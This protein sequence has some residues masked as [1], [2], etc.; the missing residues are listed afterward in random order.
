[1]WRNLFL[2]C[3]LAVS[4]SARDTKR[5]I[6]VMNRSASKISISWVHP[7]TGERVLMSQ[8]DVMPGAEFNLDS[9]VG[10]S[11]AVVELPVRNESICRK[12]P[13]NI[14]RETSYTVSENDNQFV[15]ITEEFEAEF[16]DNKIKARKE[17]T[18]LVEECQAIAKKTL[19]SAK[20]DQSA[21]DK[22]M[23]DLVLCV[24]GGVASRLEEVNEEI[25]FQT[26]VRKSIAEKL[27]NYTCIDEK[28][29]STDDV[30]TST[31]VDKNRRRR[32]VHVKHDRPASQIHV[33]ENFISEEECK[34]MEEQAKPKL[35]KATVADGR[36]GS[37]LSENRKAMQAGIKVPWE[38]E[39][40]GDHIAKLSR[41]V[42]DYTNHVL[43]LNIDE[44]GQEDLMSIQYFGRG[45][46]D[47]EPD[48]YTPHCDGECTGQ[49][50]K[51]GTR[52]ATMVMYCTV[53]DD[54]GHTNFRNS[55]VHI[56][57][58]VG[59]AIFFS[60]IDP[61]TLIMDT[62]FTEHSGCPVFEGEKKIV[63]QWIRLGV[64]EENPWDSFNTLG[65][66][67]KDI[68]ALESSVP[69]EEMEEDEGHD[70][71]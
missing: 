39:A 49:P 12:A 58:E 10:H 7:E 66:K 30:S 36:G 56:K 71:L 1:M 21:V 44:K 25:G 46:N 40:K 60:Y 59:N 61:K 5:K 42:Y 3:W 41:R 47:E 16:V 17:A 9:F 68:E 4:A 27:E 38:L 43:G 13:D 62:G 20:D 35:H 52:M 53:A 14:C 65:I 26:R 55:G 48:R 64:D 22:A 28:L 37:R 29:E 69:D 50:H 34:A 19:E 67:Y 2:F 31:W 11:F 23:K 33:I 57:P 51:S 45:R 15:V 70:E 6:E 8:P 54:G 24:E 32:T 18:N 63:T